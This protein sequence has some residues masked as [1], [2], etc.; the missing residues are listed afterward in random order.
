MAALIV[1]EPA[2]V[3][4]LV[5][6]PILLTLVVERVIPETIALLLLS[7]RLPVPVMPPDTVSTELPLLLLFVRVLPELFTVMAVVLI[8]RAEVALFSMI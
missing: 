6:V 2:P 1:V 8:V 3:P 5:M 4:E 7:I